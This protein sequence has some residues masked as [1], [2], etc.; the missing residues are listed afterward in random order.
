MAIFHLLGLI[1]CPIETGESTLTGTDRARPLPGERGCLA[2]EAPLDGPAHR[3]GPAAC[4]E[5]RDDAA[6]VGLDRARGDIEAGRDVD[7]SQAL[8]KALQDFDLPDG[9]VPSRVS[10][11]ARRVRGVAAHDLRRDAWRQ[12]DAAPGNL[13]EGLD[14][15]FLGTVLQQVAVNA[16][17]GEGA[18][19]LVEV[20]AAE[21]EN[22]DV[23]PVAAQAPRQVDPG[24]SLH[25][26]V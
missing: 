1:R 3:L 20:V 18:D 2:D 12:D 17:A 10:A 5:L 9:Q 8:V 14:E 23:R 11:L 21:D 4:A 24:E 7:I 25:P 6:H 26:N 19:V 13:V 16:D 15:G 22:L